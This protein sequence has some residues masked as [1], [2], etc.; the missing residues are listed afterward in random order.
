MARVAGISFG[1]DGENLDSGVLINSGSAEFEDCAFR[2]NGSSVFQVFGGDSS[3]T[4][5]R[6]I[7]KNCGELGILVFG[8]AKPVIEDCEIVGNSIYGVFASDLGTVA[9]FRR[10]AVRKSGGAGYRINNQARAR[11]D[12]CEATE[13]ANAGVLI[14]DGGEASVRNCTIT[15]NAYEAVQVFDAKSGSTFENNDLRGNGRGAWDIAPGAE[16]NITRRNNR[17]D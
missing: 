15:N 12:G 10:C 1:T 11:L 3:P 13:N 9:T 6:C 16:A 14:A 7:V 5:R 4:V 8:E 2:S 17:D